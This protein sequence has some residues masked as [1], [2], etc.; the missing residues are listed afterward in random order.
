[1]FK[2]PPRAILLIGDLQCVI[3]LVIAKF[4]RDLWEWSTW[5]GLRATVIYSHQTTKGLSGV[6]D[7]KPLDCDLLLDMCCLGPTA[8]EGICEGALETH[9]IDSQLVP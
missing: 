1:M 6:I 7:A 5:K 2:G 3:T 4:A 8:L 9:S